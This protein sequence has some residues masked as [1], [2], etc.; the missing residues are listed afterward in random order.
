[1]SITAEFKLDFAPTFVSLSM[2]GL[3]SQIGEKNTSLVVSAVCR[4]SGMV[5][6]NEIRS[7][8]RN[9]FNELALLVEVSPDG[10]NDI[11]FIESVVSDLQ[12]SFNNLVIDAEMPDV[13]FWIREMAAK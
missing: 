9:V 11:N 12:K 13:M 3:A 1:M 7:E 8:R 6:G 2:P 10:D 5:D 4:M